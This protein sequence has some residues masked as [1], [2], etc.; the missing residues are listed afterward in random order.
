MTQSG[1]PLLCSRFS[2]VS[3]NAKI[4]SASFRATVQYGQ[5]VRATVLRGGGVYPVDL[6]LWSQYSCCVTSARRP[7]Q[8]GWPLSGAETLL[9]IAPE[10][11][12]ATIPAGDVK[13]TTPCVNET[14]SKS[15]SSLPIQL[16]PT[17]VVKQACRVI[18]F[19]S[20]QI[21]KGYWIWFL[22]I[23]EAL[24][25]INRLLIYSFVVNKAVFLKLFPWRNTEEPLPMKTKRKNYKETV[26]SARRLLQC[27][28]LPDKNSH[29]ISEVYLWFF[30]SISKQ[31]CV[32][33]ILFI[34]TQ[35]FRGTL[36][37]K[38]SYEA[39]YWQ[40]NL[41]GKVTVSGGNIGLEYEV[42]VAN[43]YLQ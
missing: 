26:V 35:R 24:T 31:L 23:I 21:L 12:E 9:N 11:I 20:W 36:F 5:T 37:G 18:S 19:M 25:F 43:L 15:S 34:R 30:C 28:R 40:L 16:S 3:R 39:S 10:F 13:V 8:Q 7:F 17:Y 29:D 2:S 42:T 1:I 33:S 27:F 14:W 22:R 32:C 4:S 38:H 41:C 6:F